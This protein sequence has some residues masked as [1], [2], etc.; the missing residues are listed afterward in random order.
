M[1]PS[2][3][4]QRK[5]LLLLNKHYKQVLKAS[6]VPSPSK[7]TPAQVSIYFSQ[8]FVPKENYYVPKITTDMTPQSDDEYMKLAQK[9]PKAKAA[10]VAKAPKPK[11]MKVAKAPMAAEP[12]T[13]AP[14]DAAAKMAKVRAAKKPKASMATDVAPKAKT[15]KTPKAKAAPKAKAPRKPKMPKAA[16]GPVVQ[17]VM[18]SM[19]M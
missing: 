13:M 6:Q 12:A 14:M 18:P 9:E 16:A 19:M 4:V 15:I 7:L 2:V 17:P 11:A 8:H 3:A 5:Y 10:K 1:L